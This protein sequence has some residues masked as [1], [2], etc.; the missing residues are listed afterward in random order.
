[1]GGG[2]LYP[3]TLYMVAKMRKELDE[4]ERNDIKIIASGG[5][6]LG[7]RDPITGESTEPY[8]FG[9][10]RML[11]YLKFGAYGIRIGTAV[12]IRE[13]DPKILREII[14]GIAALVEEEGGL[15]KIDKIVGTH[16]CS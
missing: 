10:I 1:V 3:F 9:S 5:I 8:H 12:G 16:F 13:A 2:I 11:N 15:E 7:Y 6:D 14:Y 4:R